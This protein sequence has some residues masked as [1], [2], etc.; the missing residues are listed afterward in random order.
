LSDL[1]QATGGEFDP[2]L[3]G[4]VRSQSAGPEEREGRAADTLLRPAVTLHKR[5]TAQEF[6]HDPA[7]EPRPFAK[8]MT[9]AVDS[10]PAFINPDA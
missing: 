8:V 9:T 7:Q 6:L 5:V 3:S 2:Q 4:S 1:D 10:R